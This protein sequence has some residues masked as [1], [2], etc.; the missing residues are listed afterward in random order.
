MLGDYFVVSDTEGYWT[1]YGTGGGELLKRSP[2]EQF[3]QNDY[4]PLR[5]DAQGNVIDDATQVS[6]HFD[7]ITSNTFSLSLHNCISSR[8]HTHT[9]SHFY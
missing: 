8:T 4:A 1:L 3:F 9:S 5:R 6:L 7:S 2:E